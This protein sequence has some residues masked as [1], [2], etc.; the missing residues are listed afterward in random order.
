M[1]RRMVTALLLA[2]SA[3][4]GPAP[5]CLEG[6]TSCDEHCVYECH[7]G[8]TFLMYCVPCG[9]SHSF[10]SPTVP[11]NTCEVPVTACVDAGQPS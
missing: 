9:Q 2:L 7:R 11:G 8:A 6:F 1:G 5:A 3:C 10:T 4:G